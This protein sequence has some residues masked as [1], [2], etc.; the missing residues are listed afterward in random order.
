MPGDRPARVRSLQ[1]HHRQ[2]PSIGPGNRAAVNLTGI[3]HDD[4]A[5]GHAVVTAGAW[6][7]TRL[8]DAELTVLD[9]LDHPVSRRGAY[10]AY[11]GSGEIPTRLRILGATELGPGDTGTVRLYLSRPVPLLPGDRFILRESGR[12]QTVG[13][14]QVLDVDPVIPAS[15]AH[16]DRSV[17]RVVAERGWMTVE[18]LR[19]LTGEVRP[20]TVGQW[21]V[22]PEALAATRGHHPPAD[23]G[24]RRPRARRRRARRSPAGGV[25]P[26][27]GGGG[28][29]RAGHG[30]PGGR[31]PGRPSVGGGPGGRPVQPA[32]ARGGRPGRGA[33]AGAAGPGGGTRRRP[34]RRRRH[35]RGG[36]ADGRA[37][38]HPT[39]RVHRGRGPRRRSAPPAST[40][41]PCWPTSTRPA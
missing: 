25:R 39:R 35:R 33:G 19:K 4:L 28:E 12:D 20:A 24:G 26:G 22:D 6:H 23:R 29:R 14:G 38:G 8:V 32:R 18:Q 16:P 17:D 1:S 2:A 10:A 41:S 30:G 13:G 34:L 36:P 21:V 40:C 15:R 3:S 11:I 31:S 7:Q 5:R 37:A 27:G 9:T